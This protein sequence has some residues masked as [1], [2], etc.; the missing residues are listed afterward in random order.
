M[1]LSCL[2]GAMIRLL[3]SQSLSISCVRRRLL[4]EATP[5]QSLPICSLFSSIEKLSQLS[6]DKV[7]FVA[8]T[9]S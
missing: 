1:G 6:G 5:D 3:S 7:E 8:E 2:S 4:S 9:N